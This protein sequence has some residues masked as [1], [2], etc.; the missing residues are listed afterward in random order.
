VGEKTTITATVT[1]SDGSTYA[2]TLTIRPADV[3]LVVEP[4]STVHPFYRG[5]SQVGSEGSVRLVAMTD[6][7]GA[8]GSRI[9][10]SALSYT[11]RV[12][13]QVLTS[14]S[15]LGRST[16]IATAPVRYRDATVSVTVTNA[17][18]SIVGYATTR[19]APVAP[20]VRIYENDPLLGPLFDRA[21]SGAFAMTESETTFRAVP[22]FFA[23][24]PAL[25][26]LIG[27]SAGGNG[28]DV[29]VRST[30][31]GAGTASVSLS[32]SDAAKHQSASSQLS[33]GFG[34]AKKLG[35]FGL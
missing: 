25:S 33:V 23:A 27:G 20:I 9:A 28:P 11:W 18:Q 19:I 1:A 24:D 6:F 3:A 26:W 22:Y 12:G 34:S 31:D 32:A 14:S 29:T 8:P 21:L 15:G 13:D 7:R 35:I 4:V 5:G 16:L 17:D 2:K 10:P 30:G